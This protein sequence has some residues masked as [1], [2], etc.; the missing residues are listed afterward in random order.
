MVCT[1]RNLEK[2]RPLVQHPRNADTEWSIA[3]PVMDVLKEGE[4]EASQKFPRA[5]CCSV[6]S[7]I[8]TCRSEL[9]HPSQLSIC[10]D[11]ASSLPGVPAPWETHKPGFQ[12][13]SRLSRQTFSLHL[14]SPSV[15]SGQ[16][17]REAH[18]HLY[19]Q[20]G[21]V[22]SSCPAH[23]P[24][25]LGI[26]GKRLSRRHWLHYPEGRVAEEAG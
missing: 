26:H 16:A 23:Q 3:V 8:C 14:F 15:F 24:P 10:A 4:L 13:A 21:A 18:L 5:G 12:Q 22:A 25:A 20:P 19:F 7:L 17:S 11:T 1:S 6:S 2:I 9:G